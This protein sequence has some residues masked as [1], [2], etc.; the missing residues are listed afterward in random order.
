MG[1]TLII[2]IQPQRWRSTVA[3]SRVIIYEHLDWTLT[4]GYGPH[5]V[6]RFTPH[7]NPARATMKTKEKRWIKK[8]APS[9][10]GRFLFKYG[11][12]RGTLCATM[13]LCGGI[14]LAAV[15]FT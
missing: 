7:E 5:V 6:G 9:L 15:A 3:G 11:D 1:S 14:V 4:L 10:L 13:K 12:L 8:F 2:E